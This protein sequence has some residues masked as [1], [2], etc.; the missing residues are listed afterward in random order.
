MKRQSCI[1]H[2]MMLGVVVLLVVGMGHAQ[3]GGDVIKVKLPFNFSIGTQRF[4]AGEYSL[5]PLLPNTMLLRNQAGQTLTSIA[6]NSVE[7]TEALGSTKLVFNSYGGQYFLRQV[8]R[9][10]N[11]TGREMIKSPVE[12]EMAKKYTPEQQIAKLCPSLLNRRDYRKA[13]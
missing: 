3:I 9:A 2:K 8:W 11:G 7:S 13:R 10:G 5:K 12:I 6:T 1:L 4:P